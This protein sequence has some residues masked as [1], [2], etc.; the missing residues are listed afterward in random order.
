MRRSGGESPSLGLEPVDPR[1]EL[2]FA[3]GVAFALTLAGAAALAAAQ[4]SVPVALAVMAGI[5]AVCGWLFVWSGAVVTAGLSW[6][7]LN[8]F[9]TDHSGTLRWHGT[10]DLREITVLAATA[11]AVALAREVQLHRRGRV[12]IRRFVDELSEFVNASRP[13]GGRRA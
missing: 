8:A 4:A 6:L 2:S 9:V 12:A 13:L 3:V 5:T 11:A 1:L 7:M 10:R